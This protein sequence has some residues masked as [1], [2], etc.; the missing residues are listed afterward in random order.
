MMRRRRIVRRAVSKPGRLVPA[1]AKYLKSRVVQLGPGQVMPWH[2]TGAREELLVGLLGVVDVC[3]RHASGRIA[4]LPLAAG[5]TL[6][7]PPRTPHG[8]VNESWQPARYLYVTG[9]RAAR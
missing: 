8:V 3:V 5:S 4:R 2:T 6:F 9:G 7:L 1:W